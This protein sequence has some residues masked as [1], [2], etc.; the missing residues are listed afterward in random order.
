MVIFI[1]L[2]HFNTYI[3]MVLINS[4]QTKLKEGGAEIPPIKRITI[5]KQRND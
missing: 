4:N 1:P 3:Y 5:K 2:F